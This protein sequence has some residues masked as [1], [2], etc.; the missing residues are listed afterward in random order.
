M[1]KGGQ[2]V[3][4]VEGGEGNETRWENLENHVIQRNNVCTM[5]FMCWGSNNEKDIG[6]NNSATLPLKT[7]N[8]SRYYPIV[9]GC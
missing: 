6:Q 9:P 1:G 4:V 3:C 5:C 8:K 7:I 2:S